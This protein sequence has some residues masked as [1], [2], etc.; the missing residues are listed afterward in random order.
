MTQEL[1]QDP[2]GNLKLFMSKQGWMRSS[3]MT[4]T[5]KSFTE[6]AADNTNKVMINKGTDKIISRCDITHLKHKASIKASFVDTTLGV[7]DFE[8]DEANNANAGK[9]VELPYLQPGVFGAF[10]FGQELSVIALTLST[11]TATYMF[12]NE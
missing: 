5:Y 3:I 11:N 2:A 10:D 12:A 7:T 6:E 8:Q 9:N 4:I 1:I